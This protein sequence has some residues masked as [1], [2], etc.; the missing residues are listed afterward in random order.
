MAYQMQSG[1]QKKK[2]DPSPGSVIGSMF[3]DLAGMALN[4]IVP[5]AGSAISSGLTKA[6]DLPNVNTLGQE[7]P[8][9][10]A[11]MQSAQP[12]AQ[13]ALPDYASQYNGKPA[14]RTPQ[15]DAI[16]NDLLWSPINGK[17]GWRPSGYSQ[18][19]ARYSA[20]MM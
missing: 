16:L 2:K 20:R 7:Q 19:Q 11:P 12:P 14:Q 18:E 9:T 4:V 13:S 5:G 10:A 3:L 15:D 17:P 1:V 8:T 6:L